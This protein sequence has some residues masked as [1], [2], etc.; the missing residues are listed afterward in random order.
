MR[1]SLF[2]RRQLLLLAGTAACAT[3]ADNDFW[4]LKPASE[5][6]TGEIYR[7]MNNSPWAKT[8]SWWGP[9]TLSHQG[10]RG[11]QLGEMPREGPKAVITWESPAPVRDAMKAPP[12]QVYSNSYVIGVDT[13]PNMDDSY[14]L[15]KYARLFCAGKNKWS[16]SATGEYKLIRTSA[17]Y[18]F[19][20]ER[21][22]A[23]I[24]PDTGEVIFEI[25][26]GGW[27]I[28]SRFKTKEMLY[29]GELAL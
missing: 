16:F 26:F 19:T 20:F 28:Q 24:G 2:T 7:L 25:D 12:A 14:D 4:N 27:T 11:G 15:R 6:D 5:W 13:I 1:N 18:Q 10:I 29:R 9:K 8:V 22:N 3:A 17:V 23:P 21:A